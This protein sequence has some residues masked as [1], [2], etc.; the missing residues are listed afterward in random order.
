MTVHV[1]CFVQ[2]TV[3]TQRYE[4]HERL[5]SGL[6]KDLN[7]QLFLNITS[8]AVKQQ[9]QVVGAH[10]WI[11]TVQLSV[12]RSLDPVQLKH[13]Q[14]HSDHHENHDPVT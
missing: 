7:A 6:K 3:Q 2:P 8:D 14:N 10:L 4:A 9:Q 11:S 5:T 13:T 1:S 12:P